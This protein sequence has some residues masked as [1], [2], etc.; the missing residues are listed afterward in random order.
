M[1]GALAKRY[2]RALAS[3]ASEER[4][5]EEVGAELE[6]TADW[7]ADPELATAL[8]AP[9]LGPAARRGLIGSITESLGLSELTTN[10]LGLLAQRNRL[11]QFRSIGDAYR[12]IVDR[13][14]GRVR[15]RIHSAEPLSPASLAE[16]NRVLD[17]ICG[18]KVLPSVEVDSAL[19]G[20]LTV[21]I[22][23]RVYDGSV[24]TQLEHLTRAMAREEA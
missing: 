19:I 3:V 10:F 6:R 4:R 20:G 9:N 23:G 18:K 5:L 8:A 12:A 21:E 2:A 13:E 16:L 11:G 7:L 17:G 1:T 22:E 24:R 15:A 14:L